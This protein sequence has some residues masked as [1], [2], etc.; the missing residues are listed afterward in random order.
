MLTPKLPIDITPRALAEISHIMAKKN[1]PEG[2]FL[3]VGM[4]GGGCAGTT[5]MLGFDTPKEKDDRFNIES[6]PVLIDRKHTMYLL[7][8][9]V[10]FVDTDEARGF[11]FLNP[12]E[13][14]E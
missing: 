3:R 13:N 1:I 6:V 12:G 8:V 5:F 10:D 14:A 11:V 2:Y 9:T 7:G 4:K